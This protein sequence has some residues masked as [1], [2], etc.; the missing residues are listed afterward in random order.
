MEKDNE[1]QSANEVKVGYHQ[2]VSHKCVLTLLTPPVI[3]CLT[4]CLQEAVEKQIQ[5]HRE[6]HQRQISS[7]R[8]ELDVKEKLITELQE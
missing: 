8:D 5:S 3:S 1:I 6:A 4:V 2:S 7:L